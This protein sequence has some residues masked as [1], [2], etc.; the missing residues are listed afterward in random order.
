MSTFFE[1]TKTSHFEEGEL[2][3]LPEHTD[4]YRLSIEQSEKSADLKLAIQISSTHRSKAGLAHIRLNRQE[5]MRLMG[6]L[7]ENLLNLSGIEPPIQCSIY[8]TRSNQLDMFAPGK[9]G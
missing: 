6:G 9:A 5:V 7:L 4:I 2:S 1:I 8:S 3:Q